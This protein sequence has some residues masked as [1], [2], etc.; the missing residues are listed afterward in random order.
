MT[1]KAISYV[2]QFDKNGQSIGF[3]FAEESPERLEENES[4]VAADQ[5]D[6]SRP[7][8]W[9]RD[10]AGNVE[11]LESVPAIKETTK[12]PLF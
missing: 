10:K 6:T 4:F 7:L 3:A 11:Q 1:H 2:V 12:G 9:Q 5:I 8:M